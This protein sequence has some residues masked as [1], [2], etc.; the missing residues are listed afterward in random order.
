MVFKVLKQ[1]K[2]LKT[3]A[4]QKNMCAALSHCYILATSLDIFTARKKLNLDEL[5]KLQEGMLA[6]NANNGQYLLG[7]F[8]TDYQFR[9]AVDLRLHLQ[10]MP[11]YSSST[12]QLKPRITCQR[13]YGAHHPFIVY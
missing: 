6:Y 9:N 3:I 11:S 2:K 7:N 13:I 1:P 10:C 4:P 8:L 5:I 12:N